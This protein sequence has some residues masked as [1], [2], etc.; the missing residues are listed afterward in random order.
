MNNNIKEPK[1]NDSKID[2]TILTELKL[3]EGSAVTWGANALTPVVGIKSAVD[4]PTDELIK[5]LDHLYK[6]CK[7]GALSDEYLSSVEIEVKQLQ[8]IIAEK[9]EAKPIEEITPPSDN[10]MMIADYL[11][12]QIKI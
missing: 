12:S 8:Q 3:W 1:N 2:Y 6:V 10:S 9:L 11:K 4:I 5:R 7:V